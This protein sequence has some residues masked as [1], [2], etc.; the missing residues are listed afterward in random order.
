VKE[1]RET[2][3]YDLTHRTTD[4]VSGIRVF[5]TGPAS[6]LDG[7]MALSLGCASFAPARSVNVT[8]GQLA[9]ALQLRPT[10]T[11]LSNLYLAKG[12]DQFRLYQPDGDHLCFS[13][14]VDA[15]V[16]LTVPLPDNWYG[17][18]HW[19][20][21]SYTG[22]TLEICVDGNRLGACAARGEIRYA[23]GTLFL[24]Y[25]PFTGATGS[26]AV[27]VFRLYDQVPA[28]MDAPERAPSRPGPIAEVDF[29]RMFA[30]EEPTERATP[31]V[32]ALEPCGGRVA[33]R[34]GPPVSTIAPLEIKEH[35]NTGRFIGDGF[36]IEID[37]PTA[38]I[39]TWEID[40]TP[41]VELG[42]VHQF[43]R[44]P[45]LHEL[46]PG[47][48]GESVA[49]QWVKAGYFENLMGTTAMEALQ[50]SPYLVT[51]DFQGLIIRR[52]SDVLF[53][54]KRRYTV[55][56]NGEVFLEQTLTPEGT[57]PPMGRQG[58]EIRVPK[59]FRHAF[60]GP[61]DAVAS[62]DGSYRWAALRNDEGF[63]ILASSE[64]PLFC[65]VYAH[66]A[67][68]RSEAIYPEFLTPDSAYTWHLDQRLSVPPM[69][70]AP[71]ADYG[72]PATTH[73]LALRLRGLRPSDESLPAIAATGLPLR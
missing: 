5:C 56:G 33:A 32:L 13:I 61:C 7:V 65:A 12:P 29:G 19:V 57:L 8:G 59:A 23:P 9:L 45:A 66:S 4:I 60:G 51:L 55:Y 22:A 20:A 16:T 31:E 73:S 28:F 21:V 24:G 35:E 49:A 62:G 63:G 39:V 72:I 1:L 58:V 48:D 11:A 6:L 53:N 44:A 25:D 17:A 15:L 42:P 43:W 14:H 10:K 50:E 40:G 36:L 34:P 38:T 41:L 52:D 67:F 18:W 47:G 46:R 69:P 26:G 54:L 64:A 71:L 70:G 68:Q 3:G 37:L 2:A 30:A 27:G